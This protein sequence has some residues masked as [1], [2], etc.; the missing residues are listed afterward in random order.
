MTNILFTF[1]E[2]FKSTVQ[3]NAV[4]IYIC[5]NSGVNDLLCRQPSPYVNRSMQNGTLYHTC[6]AI[7]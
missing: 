7:K 2:Y 6:L 3:R 4:N 1:V 5:N